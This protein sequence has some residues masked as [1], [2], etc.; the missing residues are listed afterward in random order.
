MVSTPA[1]MAA[2]TDWRLPD[3]AS[4]AAAHDGAPAPWSADPI[5]KRIDQAPLGVGRQPFVM[6]QKDQIGE[7]R[8]P[9]QVED[10]MSPDY[11]CASGRRR[12]WRCARCPYESLDYY[13][14][15]RPRRVLR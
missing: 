9:H 14:A 1:A 12:R 3:A 8:S 4:R 15:R 2:D 10:V 13:A 6:Q 7:R 5:R 11:E